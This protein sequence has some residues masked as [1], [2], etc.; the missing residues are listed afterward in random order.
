MWYIVSGICFLI[1]GLSF[2]VKSILKFSFE[3]TRD[4]LEALK[5]ELEQLEKI[6]ELTEELK[7]KKSEIVDLLNNEFSDFNALFQKKINIE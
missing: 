7:I 6:E 4:N 1:I 3:R 2:G 5:I